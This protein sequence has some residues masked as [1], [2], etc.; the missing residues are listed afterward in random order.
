MRL[1]HTSDFKPHAEPKWEKARNKQNDIDKKMN[2]FKGIQW[3]D[4]NQFLE[5]KPYKRRSRFIYGFVALLMGILLY[6]MIRANYSLATHN[7]YEPALDKFETIMNDMNIIWIY[8]SKY[9]H[10]ATFDDTFFFILFLWGICVVYLV[11]IK[12]FDSPQIREI[13]NIERSG[14]SRYLIVQDINNKYGICDCR[15]RR[16]IMALPMIYDIIHPCVGLNGD[17]AYICGKNNLF[18]VYNASMNKLV[19]PIEYDNIEMIS[20]GILSASK[21]GES[22]QFTT[23]GYRIIKS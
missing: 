21:K 13:Y 14:N 6:I 16:I 1:E 19:I 18:G 7:Y 8:D 15:P 2:S 22:S 5:T 4:F 12:Y 20:D 10:I 17:K 3:I 11:I 9:E 23:K